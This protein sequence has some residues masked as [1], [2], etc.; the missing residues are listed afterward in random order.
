MTHVSAKSQQE[1]PQKTGQQ[2]ASYAHAAGTAG[3]RDGGAS[4]KRSCQTAQLQDFADERNKQQRRT[5]HRSQSGRTQC[6][7]QSIQRCRCCIRSKYWQSCCVRPR[8]WGPL[9]LRTP[10]TSPPGERRLGYGTRPDSF[11]ESRGI[12]LYC[13]SRLWSVRTLDKSRP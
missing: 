3:A 2:S 4:S 1:D 12:D 11:R 9:I 10:R 6:C 7:W 13:G 8:P 5:Y